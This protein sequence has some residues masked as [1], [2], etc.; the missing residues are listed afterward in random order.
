[1]RDCHQDFKEKSCTLTHEGRTLQKWRAFVGKLETVSTNP[2]RRAARHRCRACEAALRL[3]GRSKKLQHD[4]GAPAPTVLLEIDG[5]TCHEDMRN[6]LPDLDTTYVPAELLAP[7]Q[8]AATAGKRKRVT[9][10]VG[11]AG[12]MASRVKVEPGFPICYLVTACNS[13]H[14]HRAK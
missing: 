14:C 13:Q 10:S 12:A 9:D 6:F 8:P 7:S 1:V 11:G 4:Y 5:C 2:F 3:S